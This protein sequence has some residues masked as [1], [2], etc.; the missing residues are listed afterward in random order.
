MGSRAREMD[1]DELAAAERRLQELLD[2]TL[3]EVGQAEELER[4]RAKQVCEVLSGLSTLSE[5]FIPSDS[6][7]TC[8]ARPAPTGVPRGECDLQRKVDQGRATNSGRCSSAA[9]CR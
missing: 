6:P 4:Q 8:L 3:D 2:T 5:G 9:S 1:D 7:S